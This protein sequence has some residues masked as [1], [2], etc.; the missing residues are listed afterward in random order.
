MLNPVTTSGDRRVRLNIL[1]TSPLDEMDSRASSA[2]STNL[3]HELVPSRF[4]VRA[5]AD[6]GRLLLWNTFSRSISAFPAPQAAEVANA[7]KAAGVRAST[8]GLVAYLHER[9]FLVPRGTDEYQRFLLAF[10]QSHYRTDRLELFVLSSEDCNFRCKYCYEDFA[11]G[12]M[13]PEIRNGIKRWVERRIRQLE[14]LHVS[15][16]GG[17][18]LY[19]WAAVEDLAPWFSQIAQQHGALYTNHM[20]TNG[21][22]LTPNVADRLFAWRINNFQIT[23]DGLAQDHDASR[24]TRDGQGTFATIFSNL[25]S[26]ARRKSDDFDVT[27]RVNFDQENAPRLPEFVELAEKEFRGDSRF[28]LDFHPVGRWGGATDEALPLCT[29]NEQRRLM[30]E[31]KAKAY[32]SGLRIGSLKDINYLGGQ[33]CYAARPYNLIVGATGKIMKCTILLDKD[34][35]NV[36]GQLREDGELVLNDARLARWTAPSFESDAQ[37]QKCVVLPNCSGISCPLPR[38][39]KGE[40]PCIPTR[41]EAKQEL[42]EL[43]AYPNRAERVRVVP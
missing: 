41:T 3:G 33:I 37:C 11:R 16:F 32:Q 9:G 17:E 6:D 24:P 18:P 38:I 12:T 29:E 2:A 26:L 31:L 25:Q 21:Y 20:T 1:Q 7:L 13:R 27:L 22:L 19:G 10:G 42:R 43:L 36:V 34:E 40:R 4:N 23:V 8:T 39:Q 30:S 28:R 15:W 14:V 35:A 5:V